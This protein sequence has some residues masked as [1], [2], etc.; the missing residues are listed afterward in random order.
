[1][2]AGSGTNSSGGA[3]GGGGGGHSERP[4]EEGGLSVDTSSTTGGGGGSSPSATAP[5]RGSKRPPPSIAASS[6]LDPRSSMSFKKRS[7]SS[8]N[9][10]SRGAS[11]S[12]ASRG[13]GTA[14]RSFSGFLFGGGGGGGGGSRR[15][16]TSND[17]NAQQ[18]RSLAVPGVERWRNMRRAQTLS[19][20]P[21]I[22]GDPEDPSSWSFPEPKPQIPS[23]LPNQNANP[24][25]TP[26]PLL[27]FTVLC[28]VCFG[29]FSSS[30]VAGPFLFFMIDSFNVGGESQV[31]FW[32]GI[33]ASV[34]FFAQFL[35]SLLWSSIAD[36]YGRRAV[37]LASL[38][39]NAL[40][41][42][43][44]GAS[45]NLKMALT[46][47]MA[48]GL[49]N[50]AVGVAKGAI[51]D[52]T[53]PTNEG[54]AYAILGF[55][56]GFGGIAGPILGGILEH[57]A[58]KFPGVFGGIKLFET[59]PYLL[60]CLAGASFT[61]LGAILSLF[62]GPDG[63]PRQGQIRLQE[64]EGEVA[65]TTSN[66][67]AAGR[68]G[69]AA[70]AASAGQR[71]SGLFGN[72]DDSNQGH[73][74]QA[75]QISL[76]RTSSAIHAPDGLPRTFTQQVD[77]ETG[78]PPSPLDSDDEGTIVT[79]RSGRT[80][81]GGRGRS[82]WDSRLGLGFSSS[83]AAPSA[84]GF[85]RTE[86]RRR[87]VLGGGSAY[88]YDSNRFST[89]SA[90]GEGLRSR[91]NRISA[92][93]QQ[94]FGS[95]PRR[96]SNATGVNR[97][98]YT[99]SAM[100]SA[101]NYAPDFEAVGED[102]NLAPAPRKLN[103][104]Q[105]FLLANDDAV[106]SITD[107]WVAAA[108]NGDEAS[109]AAVEEDDL[110]EGD[111]RD[112]EGDGD[113]EGEGDSQAIDSSFDIDSTDE[114]DEDDEV[115][116]GRERLDSMDNSRLRPYLP[117]LNIAQRRGSRGTRMGSMRLPSFNAA[118]VPSLYNNTGI[119]L[120][121]PWSE[122]PT[123]TEEN[124]SGSTFATS[125]INAPAAGQSRYDPTLAGIP[126]SASARNTLGKAAGSEEQQRLLA[127]QSSS[128][129]YAATDATAKKSSASGPSAPPSLWSL[130][131]MTIIAHY[132]L[133]AFHSAT[134]DQVFMAFLVTPF[135]SGGLGLT[136]A[137]Y[138]ELISAMAF[139]Q[140]GFQFYFYPK[141][142][143]PQGKWSH[144]AMMR[145]G[146]ALY[147][148]TYI[149]FPLLRRFLH[150]QTDAAV[151]TFMII[152][153]SMRWLANICA[154]TAVSILMNALTPPNLVPL[155]NGLAQTT[156]SAARFVGP[157]VGGIVW[158]KGIQPGFED[159]AWP[160]SYQLGFVFVGLA[161]FTGFLHATLVL[162]GASA[163]A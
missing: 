114:L 43:I 49:F 129:N 117:P 158:A 39:G 41:L 88:G 139:C 53:D 126:E 42:A 125:N 96:G 14:G 55:A 34:F 54:R 22:A 145:L 66:A 121:S 31:G 64:G 87:G 35:T 108:I 70:V 138:A 61:T 56:W 8:T 140:I 68:S 50:G 111:E 102:P 75:S 29:E 83:G 89:I 153:A 45:T 9:P 5:R 149:L 76:G 118:R 161:G 3:G 38:C 27:P 24:D 91:N 15:P 12:V 18:R 40:T 94:E 81:G 72:D 4:S 132:G 74:A 130:L 25:A 163:N 48:Q 107:L 77:E 113:G 85:S 110:D 105:R 159:R 16:S 112:G 7:N 1:M 95:Q 58:E 128:S 154:F 2:T 92:I 123:P 32:A 93:Q 28:L 13:G 122:G 131:P 79:R 62:I 67:N 51:R 17:P 30:G 151:M 73:T 44:F 100:G 162:K 119:D 106:L 37:L 143:P 135:P 80:H 84:S 109:Y 47:R 97:Y 52:L 120:P 144:L 141:I 103:F 155:A 157:I 152:F 160:W 65:Q 11:F 146:T 19:V 21:P 59:Y 134:F 78:G 99:P 127:A 133:L 86:E 124:P 46:V 142:G 69:L 136:A 23:L 71:I 63:G 147:L 98:S 26:L 10:N 33:T 104:A 20:H 36:R 82:D 156:S 57:P 116:A 101:Y 6:Q 150:P 115:G 137:H 60:P 148:P 90:G